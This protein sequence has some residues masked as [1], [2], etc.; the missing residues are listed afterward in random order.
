LDF[1]RA[2]ILVVGFVLGDDFWLND[3]SGHGLV[4][5]FTTVGDLCR[6]RATRPFATDVTIEPAAPFQSGGVP[7]QSWWEAATD[8]FP[9]TQAG[10]LPNRP[11]RRKRKFW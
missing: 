5:W 7:D 3:C 9:L 1:G 11:P 10:K 2:G 4:V 6:P 8:G